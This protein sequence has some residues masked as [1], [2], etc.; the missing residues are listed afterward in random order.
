[1]SRGGKQLLIIVITDGEPSDTYGNAKTN[2]F[3]ELKR[4][5]GTGLVHVSFAECTDKVCWFFFFLLLL[6]LLSL[7]LIHIALSSMIGRRHGLFRRMGQ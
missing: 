5:T 4:V 7:L 1:L 6:L 2:L 3:N